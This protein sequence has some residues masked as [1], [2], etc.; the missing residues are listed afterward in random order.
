[1]MADYPTSVSI[2]YPSAVKA[3][4]T[5]RLDKLE[6]LRAAMDAKVAK[7][8]TRGAVGKAETRVPKDGADDVNIGSLVAW[9]NAVQRGSKDNI[10]KLL[11]LQATMR[12]RG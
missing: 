2:D 3:V 11:N 9:V 1:M 6:A 8:R 4:M 10:Q 7:L 5:S 12:R